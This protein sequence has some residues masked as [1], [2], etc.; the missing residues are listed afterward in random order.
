MPT[1]PFS[2]EVADYPS[3]EELRNYFQAYAKAF[4]LYPIIEFNTLV[5]SCDR[6]DDR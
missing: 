4:D 6:L 3:H 5:K 1:F 2:D